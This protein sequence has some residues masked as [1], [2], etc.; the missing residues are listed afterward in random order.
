[1][2]LYKLSAYVGLSHNAWDEWTKAQVLIS[3]GQ[4][5]GWTTHPC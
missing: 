4:K 2:I 3:T 1:V 5:T